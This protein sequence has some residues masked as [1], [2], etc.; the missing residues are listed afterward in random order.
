MK[1]IL[2][3][4]CV[5]IMFFKADFL[6]AQNDRLFHSTG[7]GLEF[8]KTPG[9]SFDSK[10]EINGSK[11]DVIRYARFQGFGINLLYNLR[12]NMIVLSKEKAIG[13][14]LQP[15][16]AYSFLYYKTTQFSADDITDDDTRGRGNITIP[17][18]CSLDLGPG[19]TYYSEK[20]NGFVLG[21]G[22]QYFWGP[23]ITSFNGETVPD[24]LRVSYIE[25]IVILGTRYWNS[26]NKLGEF[27]VKIGYGA[28]GEFKK[29]GNDAVVKSRSISLQLNW[30]K[31]LNY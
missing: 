22:V 6:L 15:T 5:I 24:D 25:P 2:L 23:A 13:L 7:L 3:I 30:N 21:L 16:I 28:N 18:Y 17:I 20:N 9:V 10:A 19:S 11:Q 27:Q 12:Y 4:I 8:T 1:R 31:V 26:R 14:N 29:N